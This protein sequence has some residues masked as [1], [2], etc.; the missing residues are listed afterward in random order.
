VHLRGRHWAVASETVTGT[1][2]TGN[3]SIV[4]A[5]DSDIK[6]IAGHVSQ[7]GGLTSVTKTGSLANLVVIAGCM[8]GETR[9]YPESLDSSSILTN[10]HYGPVSAV[11]YS[12]N[13]SSLLTGSWDQRINRYI[14]QENGTFQWDSTVVGHYK[15]IHT[16]GWHKDGVLF[17]SGS[18]DPDL[19][20][21]DTRDRT[22]CRHA[23]LIPTPGPVFALDWSPNVNVIAVGQE[24][25]L[26]VY[27][28]RAV[29]KPIY[30]ENFVAEVKAIS[31]NPHNEHLLAVGSDSGETC[32]MNW[33]LLSQ[34]NKIF[35][36]N[37]T[38]FVR[39]VS[40]SNE[41]ESIYLCGGGWGRTK[42]NVE[43]NLQ[44]CKI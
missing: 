6:E 20:T 14:L 19:K 34:S 9:V 3:L 35:S 44:L 36:S 7:T 42:Q 10:G 12:H 5:S 13:S 43:A 15:R 1:L 18:H 37:K 33:S 26:R 8:D 11:T 31:F 17:A 21:W 4:Q 41:K 29:Q 23:V 2:W 22:N 16:L 38:D 28:M 24:D 32:V 40:W 39:T 30:T 27:D 25:G